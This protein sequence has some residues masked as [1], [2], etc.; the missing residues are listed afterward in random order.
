MVAMG[1]RT[2]A[3]NRVMD[4]NFSRAQCYRC[5]GFDHTKNYCLKQPACGRCGESHFTVWATCQ[6]KI[7][8]ELACPNCGGYLWSM[9]KNCKIFV[10]K[11]QDK[12]P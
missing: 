12:L 3:S 11:M 5:F 7:I 8:K 2:S 4:K 9:T 10:R 1:C 6:A